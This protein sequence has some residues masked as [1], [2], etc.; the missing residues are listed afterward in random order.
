MTPDPVLDAVIRDAR[1]LMFAF[2]GPIRSADKAKAADSTAATAPTSAHL[3][4]T[5]AAC[6]ESGR[7]AA[8]IS[9]NSPTEVRHYLDVH[10]LL[11]QVAVVAV[12]IGEAASTL[13]A[14]PVDCLL[15]TSSPADIEAAQVAGAP[16]IGYAR[17]PADAAHL[18]D[19]GA[20]AFVYSMADVALRLR[21]HP[22]AD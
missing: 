5:L 9:A 4:E 21:A 8:V 17:T 12:S 20:T 1:H 19:A 22:S 7:S 14:S 15:V 18:V 2:D 10:D 6:R 16:S 3:H 13:E 11:T